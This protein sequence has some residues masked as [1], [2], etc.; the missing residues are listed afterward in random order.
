MTTTDRGLKTV[1]EA[2]LKATCPG[3]LPES[4]PE[5]EAQ[6]GGGGKGAQTDRAPAHGPRGARIFMLVATEMRCVTSW[7]G[8]VIRDSLS[9][10]TCGLSATA[11]PIASS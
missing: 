2:Q 1:I 7:D 6:E 5:E 8:R 11:Q 3:A 4:L 10:D 9:W